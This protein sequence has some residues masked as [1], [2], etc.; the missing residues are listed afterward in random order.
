MNFALVYV[1]FRSRAVRPAI[2]PRFS[3]GGRKR[4]SIAFAA[5]DGKRCDDSRERKEKEN[6]KEAKHAI[7]RTHHHAIPWPAQP[8]LPKQ[9][10]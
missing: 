6:R 4:E 5:R 3:G 1:L 9:V 2:K 10:V 8:P 7:T